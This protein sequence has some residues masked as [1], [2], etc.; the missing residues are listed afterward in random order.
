MSGRVNPLQLVTI[1]KLRETSDETPQP[2]LHELGA[3]R[4]QMVCRTW[5]Q[6]ATQRTD[7]HNSGTGRTEQVQRVEQHPA[8][9]GLLSAA[10]LQVAVHTGREAGAFGSVKYLL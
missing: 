1:W 3:G 6:S 10:H 9:G 4:A 5:G 7:L 8:I 2:L